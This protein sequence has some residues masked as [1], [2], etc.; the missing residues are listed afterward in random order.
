MRKWLI[1]LLGCAMLAAAEQ[2]PEQ[3]PCQTKTVTVCCTAMRGAEGTV[4]SRLMR[5]PDGRLLL[6]R[7]QNEE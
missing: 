5:D 2:W 6:E 3:P 4:C 1:A 7:I